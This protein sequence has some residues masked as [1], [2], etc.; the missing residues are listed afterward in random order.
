M[1]TVTRLNGSKVT[2]NVLLIEVIEET[3]DTVICLTTGN[4]IVV[5]EDVPT[6]IK[7][8]RDY[9]RGIGIAQATILDHDSEG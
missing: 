7:L 3:P 4:K 6:V 8:S 1:I 2:V 9:L 5:R